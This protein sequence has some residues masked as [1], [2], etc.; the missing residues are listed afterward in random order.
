MDR[1]RAW[2]E[3]ARLGIVKGHM[4]NATNKAVEKPR[5][6]NPPL[7]L[8]AGAY[9]KGFAE[10]FRVPDGSSLTTPWPAEQAFAVTHV[11]SLAGMSDKTM[12][13]EREEALVVS[14]SLN[15]IP[16]GEYKFW[17]EGK[18]REVPFLP[19]LTTSVTDMESDPVCWVTAPF[20]Y[21]HYHVPRAGLDDIARSVG[22]QPIGTYRCVLAEKD[23]FLAQL[24]KLVLPML[25][26]GSRLSAMLLDHISLLLGAH[27]LQRYAGLPKFPEVLRGGLAPWQKRKATDFL[28][29]NLASNVRLHQVAKECGLSVSH[30]ARSFKETFGVSAHRWLVR[31]RL[32]HAQHLLLVTPTPLIEIALQSGFSDQA[33]F[34]RTFTRNFAVSPGLWRKHHRDCILT[35]QTNQ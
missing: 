3:L 4:Q 31:K 8:K 26:S 13:F 30:F 10:K 29:D 14:V 15:A 23:L 32:S 24:T 9:G 16:K 28:S 5:P 20:D 2:Q 21:I 6:P 17:T 34:T 7:S 25:Q 27:I 19:P 11:L 18:F 1:K 12:Q 33:S 35:P 22:V